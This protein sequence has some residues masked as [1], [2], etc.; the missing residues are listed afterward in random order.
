[1]VKSIRVNASA[2]KV[3]SKPNYTAVY[4]HIVGY[5]GDKMTYGNT[6]H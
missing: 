6:F 1:M 3:K 4:Q 5:S 2:A